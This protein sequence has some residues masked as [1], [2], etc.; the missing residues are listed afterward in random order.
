MATLVL[1]QDDTINGIQAKAVE[2]EEDTKEG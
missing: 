2:I 1:Q